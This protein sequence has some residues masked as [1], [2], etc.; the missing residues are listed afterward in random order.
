MPLMLMRNLNP[1]MGLCNGTRLIF[2]SIHNTHLLQCKIVGGEYKD[3]RVLI[4]RITLRPKDKEYP[5]EWTRR[6]FPVRIAFAMTIN[7][8]QG[9]TLQRVGVWLYDP[10]FAHGQLY[11]CMSRVGSPTNL[12]FAIRQVDNELDFLTRNVVYKEVLVKG[13]LKFYQNKD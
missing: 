10:C 4:P 12:K 9:Q 11:V 13:K 1:K 3:R 6:Q 7:K 2:L 8:S 5:F